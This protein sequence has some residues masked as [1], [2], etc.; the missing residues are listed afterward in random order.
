V[1]SYL[2]II[3]FPNSFSLLFFFSLCV[4][5]LH[6]NQNKFKLSYSIF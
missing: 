1:S 3:K 6:I 4:F 2:F 5:I